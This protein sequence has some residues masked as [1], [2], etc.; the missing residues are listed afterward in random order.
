MAFTPDGMFYLSQADLQPSMDTIGTGFRGML[1]LQNK[2][3][4]VNSI[5]QGAD[6]DTPEGRRAALDQIRQIDPTRA[7]ALTKQNQEYEARELSLTEKRNTPTLKAEWRLDV[8]K[9][10]TTKWATD[11]IPGQ[12]TDIT[13]RTGL[14]KYL[15]TLVRAGTM[16]NTEK[17]TW[18]K[19]YDASMKLGEDAY[20]STNAT[21][22]VSPKGTI[23]SKEVFNAS[24]YAPRVDIEGVPLVTPPTQ[25]EYDAD[26]RPVW[27]KGSIWNYRLPKGPLNMGP[28]VGGA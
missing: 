14:A 18:L 7:E 2:E 25:E 28:D 13:D 23:S 1:G 11:N 21:R 27:Q 12:P 17:N 4:A 19:D 24:E 5:L 15:L 22:S 8:G 3:E 16:K 6:Y 10:F 20:L 9:K 26:P